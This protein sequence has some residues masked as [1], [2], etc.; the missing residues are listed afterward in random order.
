[1]KQD[2]YMQAATK[3]ILH[4][5]AGCETNY[6]EDFGFGRG[7]LFPKDPKNRIIYLV[8]VD[9]RTSFSAIIQRTPY[10]QVI[11]R[12]KEIAD[13]IGVASGLAARGR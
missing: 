4:K 5:C 1:M 9:R 7:F 10:R 2:E 6:E 8:K 12:L 3:H 11:K 13:D